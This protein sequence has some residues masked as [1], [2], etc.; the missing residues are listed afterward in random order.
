[1]KRI[2]TVALAFTAL[3]TPALRLEGSARAEQK[4]AY[5][6]LHDPLAAQA[7]AGVPLY[8]PRDRH[9]TRTGHAAVAEL[10][11]GPLAAVMAGRAPKAESQPASVA[12]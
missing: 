12:R 3:S 4:I 9:L 1:M 8:F 6:D 2:L 10:I 11:R 5:V 7:R